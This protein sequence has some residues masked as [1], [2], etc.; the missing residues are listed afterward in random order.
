MRSSHILINYEN[1]SKNLLQDQEKS[2]ILGS[3]HSSQCAL[4]GENKVKLLLED[5]FYILNF[6]ILNY[7]IRIPTF[8]NNGTIWEQ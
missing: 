2:L 3:L 1:K 5:W 8:Y 4:K 6:Y 7:T